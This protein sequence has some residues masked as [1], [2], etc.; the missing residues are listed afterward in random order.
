MNTKDLQKCSVPVAR[1]TQWGGKR[2]DRPPR[3]QTLGTL[4]GSGESLK[5]ISEE[6]T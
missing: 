5:G 4:S 1:R 2:L 6:V 3:P